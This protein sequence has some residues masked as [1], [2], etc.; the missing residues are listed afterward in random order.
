[1]PG[2]VYKRRTPEKSDLDR[3]AY[4][5]FEAYEKIYPERYEDEYGY[6]RKIITSTICKYLDCR[7]KENGFKDKY[8][9]FPR[10]GELPLRTMN[11]PSYP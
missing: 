3:I 5:Q 10:H 4:Q 9:L 7:I 8:F 6:F 11:L 1:M 2:E